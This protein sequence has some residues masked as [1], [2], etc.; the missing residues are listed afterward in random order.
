MPILPLDHPEQFLATFG[1]MLYPAMEG[2]DPR[3]ARAYAA[4]AL[5]EP[6]RRLHESGRSLSYDALARIAMDAGQRL[7]DFD[8]RWWGGTATGEVFW[9][10]FLLSNLHRERASWNN[11]I[12]YTELVSKG[13]NERGSRSDFWQARGRFLTVAH[14]WTAWSIRGRRVYGR[15]DFQLFLTQAEDLRTWGQGWR[16][17]RA[18]SEPLLPQGCWRVPENWKAPKPWPDWP[19]TQYALDP[20]LVATLKP[21]GRPRKSR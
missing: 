9:I 15:A 21:S 2:D 1:V 16:P 7:T 4:Q 8:E 12:K 3:R 11:A 14:L 18:K 5:A 10:L 17:P 6:I 20:K 13:R 19:E